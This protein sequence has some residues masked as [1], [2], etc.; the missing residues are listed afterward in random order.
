MDLVRDAAERGRIQFF[1]TT[2]SS[3]VA[4]GV[5]P[6]TENHTLWRFSRREDG[7]AETIPCTTEAEVVDAIDSLLKAE[8]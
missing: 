5:E 2:H 3:V 1:L 7:S 4:E 8:G 6:A